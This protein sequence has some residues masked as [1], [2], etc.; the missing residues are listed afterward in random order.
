MK[1]ALSLARG[2]RQEGC[3]VPRALSVLIS[4]ASVAGPVT[5]YWL[6]RRRCEVTVVERAPSLRASL[7]GHAVDLFGPAVDIVEWMGLLPQIVAARTRTTTLT[8]ERPGH[9]PVDIDYARAMTAVSDRHVEIMRGELTTILNRATTD[10]V[11]S[12]FGNSV[13]VL[14][15]TSD[16]VYVEFEHGAPRRFDVV[17]GADGLH[18]TVRLLVFG[19]ES[20]YRRYLGGY[21]AAFSLPNVLDLDNRM[22]IYLVPG[23]IVGFYPVHQ[24]SQA[25]AVFIFRQDQETPLDHHDPNQQR[26]LMRRVFGDEGW[27]V[28]R[29]LE[30]MDQADDLYLDS[31]SQIRLIANAIATT[32]ITEKRASSAHRRPRTAP[33]RS[34][35]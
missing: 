9:P 13:A 2:N 30:E 4:G 26:D 19:E 6:A 27:H 21:F 29:L 14:E 34:G 23:R 35:A 3:H 22:R 1:A 12:L 32:A 15:E 8:F 18:S 20:Q 24:T 28:P 31:I 17:V 10:T 25:R 5:A 16:G 33:N 11:E 7:G